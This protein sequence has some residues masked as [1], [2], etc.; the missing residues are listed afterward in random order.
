MEINLEHFELKKLNREDLK[1]LIEWANNE[2][3]NPGENDFDVF[4][5]TDTDGYYGFYHENKLIAGGAI[6]SYNQVF[7]FMGLFIVH[8]EFRGHKIGK[9]LWYL[10]RDL[11][12]KRLKKGATIGMDGVVEMQAFYEKGGFKTAYREE[13]FEGIGQEATLSRDV[14]SIEIEDFEKIANYDFKCLGYKRKVFLKNW[15]TIPNSKGFKFTQI[16]ELTGYVVLR[17]VNSGYK[18]GP[19]FANSYEVAEELY[20]ACL[21][22]AVGKPVY[23]DIPVIN[24]GAV[25]LMKKYKAKYTFECARM[26]YGDS[27]K[28]AIDKIFGITTF[29]LG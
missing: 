3:W 12:L 13:R 23:L 14:S 21:N 2:G 11:L 4:W 1:I 25:N 20:K 10:R 15:I 6:I 17:K 28:M 22:S 5:K 27:P 26:Y 18:I 9:R 24:K 16:D 19:L 8:P 29:E 7:G